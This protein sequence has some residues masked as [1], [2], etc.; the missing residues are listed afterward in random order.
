ML[1]GTLRR[2][3]LG[4]VWERRLS[5]LEAHNSGAWLAMSGFTRKWFKPRHAAPPERARMDAYGHVFPE[6]KAES[7]RKLGRPLGDAK[8][9][10]R[11]DREQR[12]G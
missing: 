7:I 9:C 11:D 10:D 12:H 8:N 5:G 1:T 4:Y 2:L 3:A 6:K